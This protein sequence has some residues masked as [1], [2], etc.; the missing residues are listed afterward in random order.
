LFLT[1]NYFVHFTSDGERASGV[2]VGGDD[3]YTLVRALAVAKSVLAVQID[4]GKMKIVI[5]L[6][7]YNFEQ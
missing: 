4:L 2:H 5:A 7:N 3:G 6:L 1:V